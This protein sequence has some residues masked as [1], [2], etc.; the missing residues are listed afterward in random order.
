[1][2]RYFRPDHRAIVSTNSP[3]QRM[4]KEICAQCL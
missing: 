3:M 1:L 4:M 2:K